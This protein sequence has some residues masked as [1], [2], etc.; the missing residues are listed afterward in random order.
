M[1]IIGGGIHGVHLAHRLLH[2]TW[3]THD[4]I[5]IIDPHEELLHEWRRCT[6]NC[7][8]RYL[9][10]PSVHHIDIDP[11]S[12]D[13]YAAL[14][15]NRREDNF[16]PPKDRP[17]VEL[18]DRHCR[19]VID[20]H[21]L[22]SLLIRG[23]AVEIQNR[24]GHVSVV[25]AEET[26]HTR[27]VLLALGMGEKPFW[28]PWAV[29]LKDRGIRV[30]HVFDPG[31]CLNELQSDGPIAVIGAGISG[32]HLALHLAEKGLDGV[33]LF[34]KKAIKTSDFDF[35]PG[36]LGPKHLDRFHRQPID[37]RRQQVTAARAKGS[38][39]RDMKLALDNAAALN[40]IT[41]IVDDIAGA[42]CQAGDVLL[43]GRRGRYACRKIVL[44]TGF[45]E[46]R[47][48]NGFIDQAIK[49]FGLKTA[50]CG[51]PVIGPS[52]QWHERV[53]VTGP[54]SELQIGPAARNIAGARHSG[55]RITDAINKHLM[56]GK[57]V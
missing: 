14:L 33:R 32:G 1:L 19:M 4:D 2:D 9:R 40:R 38:V 41:C 22:D 36:W 15:E 46:N 16:I 13:K 52:L 24:V 39:P 30:D 6:R 45:R 44:A 54:L 42:K 48:G 53:F 34:S 37:Q 51:F 27:F 17:S 25:T 28:P 21:R 31:F 18:F 43:I 57:A 56:P 20:N 29:R 10:S 5:R 3:L 23:R 35:E 8:M 11:F 50:A 55:R 26:I 47:P 49:E 12:L 7:G